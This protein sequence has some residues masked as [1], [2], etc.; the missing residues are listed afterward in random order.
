MCRTPKTNRL[1]TSRKVTRSLVHIL[2]KLDPVSFYSRF[3]VWGEILLTYHGFFFSCGYSYIFFTLAKKLTKNFDRTLHPPLRIV[4]LEKSPD[5]PIPFFS[6]RWYFI[7]ILKTHLSFESYFWF[8]TDVVV[9][10]QVGCTYRA[11]LMLSYSRSRIWMPLA[12]SKRKVIWSITTSLRSNTKTNRYN[13][14][15]RRLSHK[16]ASPYSLLIHSYLLITVDL[17]PWTFLLSSHFVCI[18][19]SS[20]S[21]LF[22]FHQ[23]IHFNIS[24]IFPSMYSRTHCFNFRNERI[25]EENHNLY[26][27]SFWK[28][29]RI[30][31][32]SS[33][34]FKTHVQILW[35]REDL[36]MLQSN[37]ELYVVDSLREKKIIFR[38][39]E[40]RS[41]NYLNF[42][43]L[44]VP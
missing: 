30:F 40:S 37:L 5:F 43:F 6:R 29:F 9:R 41:T 13:F 21:S 18:H 27:I 7:Y 28:Q 17:S 24:F 23:F 32:F 36:R 16:S 25:R 10:N 4:K 14:V 2:N 22:I 8:I 15:N 12:N 11:R 20:F 35:V 34:F 39:K 44:L 3:A 31:N 38:L 33:S 26:F 1:M 19:L 42:F